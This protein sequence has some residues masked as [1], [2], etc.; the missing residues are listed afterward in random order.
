MPNFESL[1]VSLAVWEDT[2][3]LK[4]TKPAPDRKPRR[5]VLEEI[6]EDERSF[7]HR[8]R[9]ITFLPVEAPGDY[10][11]GYM[12]RELHIKGHT[13]KGGLFEPEE[14]DTYDVA[15]FALDLG[16]GPIDLRGAI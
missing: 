15:F 1:R 12:G 3:L 7:L 9:R 10:V 5:Q 14:L 6:F 16:S 8:G 2:P 4:G 11:A 13:K